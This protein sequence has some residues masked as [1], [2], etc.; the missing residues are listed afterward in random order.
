MHSRRQLL[1]LQFV[2][3]QL[4]DCAQSRASRHNG[5]RT[6]KI[7]VFKGHIFIETKILS[8]FEPWFSEKFFTISKTQA[9]KAYKILKNFSFYHDFQMKPFTCEVCGQSFARR[10]RLKHHMERNHQGVPIP[11]I[12]T[13]SSGGM[14]SHHSNMASPHMVASPQVAPSP[15]PQ[16]LVIPSG[17]SHEHLLHGHQGQHHQEEQV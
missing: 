7:G 16:N 13:S 1:H 17:I 6:G 14:E 4:P 3:Q 9:T 10:E 5:S 2:Q 8:C 12:P 11:P 15:H